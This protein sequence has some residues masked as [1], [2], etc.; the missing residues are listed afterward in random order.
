MG[1]IARTLQVPEGTIRG[2]HHREKWAG[3]LRK[4]R[5]ELM[6]EWRL[7][8]NFSCCNP[9]TAG[10]VV[11]KNV[12]SA[13]NAIAMAA[14]DLAREGSSKRRLEALARAGR[15]LAAA[16]TRVAKMLKVAVEPEKQTAAAFFSGVVAVKVEV[17]G[18]A[19]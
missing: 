8:H 3:R 11:M 19:K 6:R 16:A 5:E 9:D 17:P 2:W 10:E 12:A 7:G 13:C 4:M 18:S 14:C 15:G 1:E